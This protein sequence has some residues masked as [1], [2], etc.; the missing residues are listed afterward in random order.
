MRL[1]P[2]IARV[3]VLAS[4]FAAGLGSDAVAQG[5]PPV[6]PLLP[7][8][9]S[10]RVV[11]VLGQPIAD[12]TVTLEDSELAATTTAS[13]RFVLVVDFV[14]SGVVAFRKLGFAPAQAT[15]R[16]ARGDTLRL[17]ARLVPAQLLADVRVVDSAPSESPTLRLTG[18]DE[19]RRRGRGVFVTGDEIQRLN[20]MRTEDVL[21]RTGALRIVD[22]AG[23]PIAVSIR[24]PKWDLRRMT[25][26][27]PCVM[28]I[29]LDGVMMPW[30]FSLSD[31][32]SPR[33]VGGIEIYKGAATMPAE[34]AGQRTDMS[35][36]VIMIWTRVR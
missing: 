27:A 19:R 11:S 5:G 33:E 36:G 31:L 2:L 10:G 30:G 12:A 6:A 23:V 24:G 34:F 9:I 16:L 4:L 20:P 22:S 35:C 26:D 1:R 17:V 21:R 8:V 25:G 28:R 29:A 3:F 15:V 18:F 7:A 14:D 13:G 32:P